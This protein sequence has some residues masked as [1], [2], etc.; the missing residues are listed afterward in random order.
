MVYIKSA[1]VSF[2]ICF[3]DNLHLIFS[4][5]TKN[6]QFLEQSSIPMSWSR[7]GQQLSSY[8]LNKW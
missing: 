3:T 2:Q 5:Q 7:L 8:A 6:I 4:L 1:W